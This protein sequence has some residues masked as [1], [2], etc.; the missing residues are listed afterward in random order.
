MEALFR[1]TLGRAQTYETGLIDSTALME[2]RGRP[3]PTIELPISV[4]P[5]SPIH[6]TCFQAVFQVSNNYFLPK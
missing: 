6:I 3:R 1:E 2:A 5:P 4:V